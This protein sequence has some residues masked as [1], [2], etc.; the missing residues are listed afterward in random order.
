MGEGSDTPAWI[1]DSSL[2]TEDS[3]LMYVVVGLMGTING[4]LAGGVGYFIDAVVF[5]L[6]AAI[7]LF[8]LG[9]VG[10]TTYL[11]YR[12]VPSGVL[13]VGM[14]FIALFVVLQPI[15]VYGPQ[16]AA[17]DQ[18][19]GGARTALLLTSWQGIFKWGLL[20][21]VFALAVMFISRLLNRRA[22][23]VV[24]RRLR[25]DFRQDTER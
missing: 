12:R 8:L 11:S 1:Q 10:T 20:S 3:A 25:R 23:R 7:W 18:G 2:F 21:G 4:V 13:A 9:W 17:A 6:H 15:V 24:S 14:Y 16:L 5:N 19:A 22:R